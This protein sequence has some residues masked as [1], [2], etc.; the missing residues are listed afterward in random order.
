MD[1]DFA[2]LNAKVPTAIAL[3]GEAARR[4][5]HEFFILFAWPA[6]QP[7]VEYRDNWHVH[8]ICEHLEAITRG[9]IKKLVINMPFRQLK[10]TLVSQAWPAWEWIHMPQL[11][12]LTASYAKDLSTRDAVA[13]R[14]IIESSRYQAAYGHLFAMSSDQNVKTRY[15]NNKGGSRVATSTD[16]AGTGFGGNRRIIDD[17][18]NPR[19]ADSPVEVAAGVEWWKGVVSTRAN[20]PERDAI[21]LVH[22]RLNERDTTGYVLAEERGWEHLVLPMRYEAKYTK[23]TI[24]GF[25]DPRTVEGELLFPDRLGEVAVSDMEHALGTYHTNAQLQQRPDPRGGYIFDRSKWKFYKAL[26][27]FDEVVISVDCTFKNLQT[28]DFVAIHVWGNKGANKYLIH[29]I[30]ERL[31]F[32]ATVEALRSVM[33]RWGDY[34]ACLVEAKANGDAVIDSLSASFGALI[35]IN[36]EGG[37]ASRA[38]AMTPELEAGNI[39]LPD[40]S[41]DPGIETFLS[42]AA[43]FTGAEGGDDDEIDAMTQFFTWRKQRDATTGLQ[44]WMQQQALAK[45]QQTEAE[46]SRRSMQSLMSATENATSDQAHT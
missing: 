28:S 16:S 8:A 5:F 45:E 17:P 23:T 33:F 15:E 1:L 43:R 3:D 32:T 46:Q 40:P 26:P 27:E 35:G 10:S 30:K 18:I 24:L 44:Q 12:Y 34:V 38:Y 6:L 2:E 25:K 21:V 36:P 14:K 13:S 20:D 9:E 29:R 22:Q 4:S 19:Q 37:K 42:S 7:N 39:F 11:Q 41:L 31:S